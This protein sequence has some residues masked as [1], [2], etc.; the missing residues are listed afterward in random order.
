MVKF[1]I[2]L[3]CYYT[4]GSQISFNLTLQPKH[5]F[6]GRLIFLEYK[7]KSDFYIFPNLELA[8]IEK[9]SPQDYYLYD[10][11][12]ESKTSIVNRDLKVIAAACGI[13]KNVSTHVASHSFAYNSHVNGVETRLIQSML[14]HTTFQMTEKYI[15]SLLLMMN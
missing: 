11:H 1:D 7:G 9:G 5:I 2:C 13:N 8:P 4:W 10:R 14:G 12:I 6:D 15:K 3:D